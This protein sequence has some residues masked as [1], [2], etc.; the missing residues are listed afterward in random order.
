MA[1]IGAE[2]AD[3]AQDEV[4]RRRRMARRAGLE[5]RGQGGVGNLGAGAEIF[6][7]VQAVAVDRRALDD[8]VIAAG[9][10]QMDGPVGGVL[11]MVVK[12][13]RAVEMGLPFVQPLHALAFP[14]RH[15]GGQAAEPHGAAERA[16]Q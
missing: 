5:V 2:L 6:D 3:A 8:L 15:V 10:L 9:I 16:D 14:E 4:Q 11:G 7:V 1:G 13:G 12:S